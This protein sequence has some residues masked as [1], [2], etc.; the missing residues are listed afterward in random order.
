M[1]GCPLHCLHNAIRN[2]CPHNGLSNN[3]KKQLRA[4]SARNGTVQ[5]V[6]HGILRI[7]YTIQNHLFRRLRSRNTSGGSQAPELYA[8]QSKSKT[9]LL[10]DA[11]DRPGFG[12]CSVAQLLE[13]PCWPK[14]R[15]P[16]GR[17]P[18]QRG[19]RSQGLFKHIWQPGGTLSGHLANSR[20]SRFCRTRSSP[21][22][23][24]I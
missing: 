17:R 21:R 24:D 13:K 12:N 16:A 11:S 14:K 9:I 5:M 1:N 18:S 2:H 3:S 22:T 20:F 4:N 8:C 23:G 19:A 6:C 7:L 10:D 15:Q